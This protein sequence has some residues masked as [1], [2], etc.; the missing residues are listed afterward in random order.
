M[1]L[2]RPQDPFQ[3]GIA[4]PSQR[5]SPGAHGGRSLMEHDGV[6][7]SAQRRR[8]VLVA[9]VAALIAVGAFVL[10]LSYSS[11]PSGTAGGGPSGG[12][13]SSGQPSETAVVART[14][15]KVGEELGLA[16]IA[17]QQLARAYVSS[18]NVNGN[19]TY[20]SVESLTSK[21]TYA[22]QAIPQG[23]VILS[24]M[25]TTSALAAAN[26]SVPG[27]VF[28]I[29]KGYVAVSLPYITGSSQGQVDGDG[30]GGYIVAGDRI[31]ILAEIDPA[32]NPNNLLGTMYWA[33]QNV[34][35]VAVG[36]STGPPPA[37][38]SPSA[39]ATAAPVSSGSGLIMIEVPEQD[40]AAL[41]Y[42]KDAKNVFLQYLVVAK[43]D[44]LPSGTPGP[45][46][47]AGPSGQPPQSISPGSLTQN[48]GG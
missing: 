12:A 32:P 22:S 7:V 11:K 46:P 1:A 27:T 9:V 40:A 23:M 21:S 38:A 6:A 15:I 41:T 34:L 10:A 35:V 29:P 47:I 25:V 26:P 3:R 20:A 43:D 4:V 5:P 44:Y 18:L 31:D 48:F 17:T 42:M 13:N 45:A 24:S 8:R 37:S 39:G 30:T 36:A 2:A 28:N 33:Y 19:S 16:N 14:G